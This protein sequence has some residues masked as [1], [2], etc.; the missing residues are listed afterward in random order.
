MAQTETFWI[1]PQTFDVLLIDYLHR[2]NLF[3]VFFEIF[4]QEARLYIEKDVQYNGYLIA[5]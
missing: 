2:P 3:S 5:R 4:V 1:Q